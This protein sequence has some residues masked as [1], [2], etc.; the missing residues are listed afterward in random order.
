MMGQQTMVSH[1]I[2]QESRHDQGEF[3]CLERGGGLSL[4]FLLY[5]N[6]ILGEES[7]RASKFRGSS[8]VGKANDISTKS[9]PSSSS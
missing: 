9:S 6:L 4:D 2:Q 7:G 3:A 8:E 1:K 5:P